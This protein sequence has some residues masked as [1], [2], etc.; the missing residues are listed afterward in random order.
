MGNFKEI[1]SKVEGIEFILAFNLKNLNKKLALS[2]KRLRNTC[3]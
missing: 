1:E 3:T 2:V